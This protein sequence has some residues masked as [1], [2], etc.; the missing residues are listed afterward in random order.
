MHAY[1]L[2]T[3][4]FGQSKAD[5]TGSSGV[6]YTLLDITGSIV[7]NRTTEGVVQVAPGI[8]SATPHF[9]HDDPAYQILW[10][11]GTAFTKTYYAAETVN[12]LKQFFELT[13]SI[14][15]VNNAVSM[16]AEV[17][18]DTRD[19]LSQLKIDV[20]LIRDFTAGRWKMMNNQMIFYKEDNLTEIARFG[21]FDDSGNPSMESV[22]ERKKI[23]S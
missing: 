6:G 19:D 15:A 18:S 21:L 2:F 13:A 11:T 22:F 12:N 4:D 9:P 10:D 1:N 3:V 7:E 16:A 17:L 14:S 20:A 8:Y 23:V 5:A